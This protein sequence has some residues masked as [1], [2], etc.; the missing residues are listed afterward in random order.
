MSKKENKLVLEDEAG[1][2]IGS[3][4]KIEIEAKEKVRLKA[5]RIDLKASD[6]IKGIIG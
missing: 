4:K 5:E 6:E 1:I 2:Y 3:G